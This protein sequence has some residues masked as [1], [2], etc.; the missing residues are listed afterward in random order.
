MKMKKSIMNL[1]IALANSKRGMKLHSSFTSVF[2]NFLKKEIKGVIIYVNI[3][4]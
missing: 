2:I 3:Y 4:I 1:L